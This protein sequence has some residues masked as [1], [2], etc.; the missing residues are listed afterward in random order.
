MPQFFFAV[1]FAFR[2]T[3]LKRLKTQGV[4]PATRAAIVRNLGLILL[5]I[6]IYHLDGKVESW[7][8][9]QEPGALR[10]PG[11]GIQARALP[12]SGPHRARLALDPARDRGRH[13]DPRRVPGRDRRPS[14]SR[15]RTRST[16][17]TPGPCRSS[18]A[19]RSAS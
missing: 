9:L 3:F 18:T 16:S 5:G 12:D 8:Q 13:D 19:A 10:L 14:I 15:S 2:L 11:P 17:I 6:V 4:W 1:G 7:E